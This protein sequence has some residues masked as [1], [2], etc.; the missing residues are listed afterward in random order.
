MCIAGAIFEYEEEDVAFD[1]M[2]EAGAFFPSPPKAPRAFSPN[3]PTKKG[4]KDIPGFEGTMDALNALSL[5][6]RT[7]VRL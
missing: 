2:M 1:M 7:K 5:Y 6:D 3:P 4:V